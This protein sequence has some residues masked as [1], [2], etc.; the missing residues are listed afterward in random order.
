M[1]LGT[2]LNW[3]KVDGPNVQRR[4][5]EERLTR[6]LFVWDHWTRLLEAM[7]GGI[8]WNVGGYLRRFSEY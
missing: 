5:V 6:I 1:Y 4:I 2:R 7:V 8:I 3:Q